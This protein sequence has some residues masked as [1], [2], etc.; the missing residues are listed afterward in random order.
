MGTLFDGSLAEFPAMVRTQELGDGSR[1]MVDSTGRVV[2]RMPKGSYFYDP[3]YPALADAVTI[4]DVEK[5]LDALVSYDAPAYLDKSDE[6]RAAEIKAQR[7]T[8]DYALV[9]YFGG[10]LLQAGQ[11][12]RGWEAFLIDLLINQKLAHAILDRLLQANLARFE[13]YAGTVGQYV[14]VIL[15]EE[16][17][18]MQDRP[19]MS[20][21]TFRKMIKPYMKRLLCA[22]R[23]GSDA[24]ILL[25]TDGAVAQLIPDFIEMGVDA[26]N[27]VQVTAAGME[28]AELKRE[29]GRDIAF[30]G[31]GCDSQ[32]VLPYGTPQQ[33]EDE[34][35]RRLDELMPGG[36]YVFASIHNI[37][38]DVPVDNVLA[39]FRTAREYGSY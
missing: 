19:L 34:A 10:H 9:G 14:D 4:R 37:L 12:L 30:W 15:F 38:P 6:Q 18:G 17:L 33:V 35:R 16:D 36:G 31:A 13:R 11:V 2:A 23:A 32:S 26:I 27:P 28:P 3:A 25:H 22:A 21:A 7:E 8:T 39:L 20:P 1:A 24:L 29:Y 5:H